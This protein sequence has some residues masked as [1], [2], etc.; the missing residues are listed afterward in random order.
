MSTTLH[1]LSMA[2]IAV[3]VVLALTLA[4]RQALWPLWCLVC[5][6]PMGQEFVVLNLHFPLFR[7]LLLAIA[8]RVLLPAIGPGVTAG[9]IFAFVASFDDVVLAQFLTDV[10]S[11]TLPRLIFE[12]VSQEI[13]PTIAAVSTLIAFATVAILSLNLLVTKRRP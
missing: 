6:M 13:N 10:H 2:L 3:L 7:V 5:L 1:P 8:V 9:A 12:N 4:R 11:R